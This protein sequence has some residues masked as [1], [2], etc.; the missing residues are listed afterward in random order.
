MCRCL[1]GR[2]MRHRQ[3][4]TP[5]LLEENRSS[6]RE[7]DK[8]LSWDEVAP[9]THFIYLNDNHQYFKM[10]LC[11]KRG[12]IKRQSRLNDII[13]VGTTRS[14]WCFCMKWR[15][16]HRHSR[17]KE[18]SKERGLND[19]IPGNTVNL[20]QCCFFLFF[21]YLNMITS[22]SLSFSTLYRSH[23]PFFALFLST[24]YS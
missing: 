11:L 22:F 24:L 21:F 12:S 1:P 19:A 23:E 13:R 4:N 10:F 3:W 5:T 18:S 17:G 6:E 9:F 20:A 8:Y 7:T 15:L 16:G 2:F 14:D